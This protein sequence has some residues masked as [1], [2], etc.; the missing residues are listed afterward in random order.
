VHARVC[1]VSSEKAIAPGFIPTD[2]TKK[3]K[4]DDANPSLRALPGAKGL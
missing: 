1:D 3:L 2:L 4:Q